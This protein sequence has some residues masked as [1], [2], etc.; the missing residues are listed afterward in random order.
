MK[1]SQIHKKLI[2]AALYKILRETY[3]RWKRVRDDEGIGNTFG[4]DI[5]TSADVYNEVNKAWVDAWLGMSKQFVAIAYHELDEDADVVFINDCAGID[6]VIQLPYTK[7]VIEVTPFENGESRICLKH[8]E[9]DAKA[10]DHKCLCSDSFEDLSW[11]RTNDTD[12]DLFKGIHQDHQNLSTDI[13]HSHDAIWD[14][15]FKTHA[16]DKLY[17]MLIGKP[18]SMFM[19]HKELFYDNN[20]G[21][22]RLPEVEMCI[23]YHHI[24]AITNDAFYKYLTQDDYKFFDIDTDAFKTS[25]IFSN[26]TFTLFKRS[27]RLEAKFE[28]GLH[29][30]SDSYYGI[31]PTFMDYLKKTFRGFRRKNLYNN[32]RMS[33]PRRYW[34]F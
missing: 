15:T 22:I 32:L 25:V 8:L 28:S 7:F 27:G 4:H 6:I 14:F 13:I 29:E 20:L 5:F 16:F 9:F 30:Y 12:M 17:D 31:D 23:F 2:L 24:N 3:D 21:S 11:D 1:Y 26:S 33:V 10:Y 34:I 18:H 19:L